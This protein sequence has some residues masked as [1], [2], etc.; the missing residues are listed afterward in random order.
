MG[1]HIVHSIDNFVVVH[2]PAECVFNNVVNLIYI[3]VH[4]LLVIVA[5]IVVTTV[6]RT[7]E[8][9]MV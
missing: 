7:V 9:R 1:H 4:H 5:G 2:L 8:A 6:D 3:H